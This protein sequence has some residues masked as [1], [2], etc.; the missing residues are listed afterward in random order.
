MRS[1]QYDVVV[2]GGGAAG[3]GA[4]IGSAQTGAK[5]L[6]IDKNPYFGGAATHSSVLTYCGFFTQADPAEQIVGGVGQQVL[7]QLSKLGLYDGPKRTPRTGTSIVLLDPE[8]TKY[9]LDLCIQQ[10]TVD[11]LLHATVMDVVEEDG[12]IRTITGF[13]DLG[14]FSVTAGAFVDA[15][16]EAN[17]TSLTE[18]TVQIGDYEGRFQAATL[19]MRIGGVGAETDIHPDTVARAINQ[20]KSANI[21]HLTKEL[22]TIVRMPSSQDMLAILVDEQTS[23]LSAFSLTKAEMSARRQAWAYLQAFRQFLPGFESAY[24]VQT[25]PKIGIRETRHIIGEET[26]TGD[27]VI[28]G[29]KRTDTIARGGWPVE[30]HPEPG[31]PNVWQPIKDHSYYD[32]PLQTLQVKG[33]QNLWAAGRIISCDPIAFASV[34]VMG[35]AFATGH[36]AGVTAAI[37]AD[38]G[39]PTLESVQKELRAQQAII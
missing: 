31:Q 1:Y 33:M 25:G 14:Q 8:I 39:R 19:M 7:D 5:T 34:R 23:G 37:H 22:G 11:P 6:L 30:L 17:L 20:A 2:V 24:L 12:K 32:I 28:A 3:V 27:D 38:T 10:S 21:E 4:A 16:G 35:T 26:L 29:R 18:Q 15:S 9:A 36:A 13:D